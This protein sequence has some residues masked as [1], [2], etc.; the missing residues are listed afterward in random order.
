MT[1]VRALI[2]RM[3]EL[4]THETFLI[5]PEARCHVTFG[6]LRE[7]GMELAHRLS[8]LGLCKGDKVGFLLDNGVFTAEL[9]LG[10]MYGGFIPVPLNPHAG[11][12][13]LAYTLG[14]A[15]ANAVFVS[16][17]Y[18]ELLRS[19]MGGTG[20]A[21][22]IPAHPDRGPAWGER[23]PGGEIP[24]PAREDDDALLVYT[25]GS[26][27]NPKGVLTS[28]G[29]VIAGGSIA[30]RAHQLS[31]GDRSLCVLPLCHANA[32]FVTLLATLSSGGSVV[33]PRRFSVLSFW[34]WVAEYRCT[35]TAL[36]P[37]F[38]SQLL[39]LTGPP[40][41]NGEADLRS[42]RFVRCSSAPLPPST[43]RA[44]E[45]KFRLP[46]IEAMG[47]TEAGGAIFSNPLPP[48]ERKIGSVGISTS[49]D[50]RIV[51]A[52]GGDVAPRESGE[53]VIRGPSVMKGYYQDP[54]ATGEAVDA[55]GWLHTGDL[56]YQ[57]DDGY[58]FLVG[59]SKELIIK[60]GENIAPQEID[61]ALARHPSVMDAA[62]VGIPDLHL[63]QDVVAYVVVR[64]GMPWSEQ[65]LLNF[66]ERELGQFKTPSRIHPV[67][68][69][70]RGPSGK[71]L[72]SRLA[73]RAAAGARTFSAAQVEGDE[74]GRGSRAARARVEKVL[75]G[76][77]A[78]IF[79]PE[80]VSVHDNFFLLGGDSLRAQQVISR[81]RVA[82]QVELP[83]AAIFESPTVAKL[84]IRVL[85]RDPKQ[86][87]PNAQPDPLVDLEL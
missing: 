52:G 82:L 72:R 51:N 56:G 48:G 12:L 59:R 27:G 15:E 36:V 53:I 29:G 25:S 24:G 42:L 57:D 55:D 26:T 9:F 28:H 38:V 70:P 8:G 84:A 54:Q 69:L 67:T 66:C 63:G 18:S 60:A 87:G 81:L 5:G 68:E 11:R 3:A 31:P 7:H 17:E 50:V 86:R 58:F 4:R 46:L 43:H 14:H 40:V 61:E 22:V 6:E 39:N 64:P 32:Q 13:H 49:F 75:L 41:R 1:T 16:D 77:W 73:E 35:W 20:R 76:I 45:G 33:I 2:D 80:R 37:T 79:R 23:D 65:A 71:L 78:E 85:E 62:A 74:P 19:A 47:M 21:T 44:F 10:S 34:D 30:V 83:L